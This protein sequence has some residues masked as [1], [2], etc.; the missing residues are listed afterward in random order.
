MARR[1]PAGNPECKSLTG[2]NLPGDNSLHVERDYIYES[3][4]EL[5]ASSNNIQNVNTT[6]LLGV[7]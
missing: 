7:D 1:V 3:V 6:L 2:Q 4:Q 5:K